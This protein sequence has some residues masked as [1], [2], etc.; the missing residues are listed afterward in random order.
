M[1]TRTTKLDR[2][3]LAKRG[4]PTVTCD[5]DKIIMCDIALS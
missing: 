5:V 4:R 3:S 1:N 2:L